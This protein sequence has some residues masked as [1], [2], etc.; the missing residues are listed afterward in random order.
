MHQLTMFSKN[1]TMLLNRQVNKGLLVLW[2][3]WKTTLYVKKSS[4]IRQFWRRRSLK[5]FAIYSHGGH[6]GH[7]TLTI[8]AN[9]HSLF[10]RMLHIKFGFDWPSGF[11]EDVC[12]MWSYTFIAPGQGQTTL[13]AQNIFININLLSICSFLA[14][15][16]CH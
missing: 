16:F 10:L 1:F 2:F 11:R 9:V 15:L 7:V 5:V 6:L 3:T 13:W 12:I 4:F 14:S 8:Y